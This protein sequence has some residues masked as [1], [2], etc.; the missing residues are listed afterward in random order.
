MRSEADWFELADPSAIPL[1]TAPSS[2]G[3]IRITRFAKG[4]PGIGWQLTLEECPAAVQ[5]EKIMAADA[6]GI[7][8]IENSNGYIVEQ[9]DKPPR[10][11][12][13]QAEWRPQAP[14]TQRC[15]DRTQMPRRVLRCVNNKQVEF[16]AA[17]LAQA[18]DHADRAKSALSPLPRLG[19]GPVKLGLFRYRQDK[20]IEIPNFKDPKRLYRISSRLV[21]VGLTLRS[22]VVHHFA[23]VM[24]RRDRNVCRWP[25]Y[26][27]L[28]PLI[29]KCISATIKAGGMVQI[30]FSG[31][32]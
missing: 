10:E 29:V 3:K 13:K 12:S 20:Q 32:G 27:L 14:V 6:A 18:S 26:A 8:K 16:S 22:F 24:S 21:F 9:M 4:E 15:E 1:I 11:N 5:Q 31:S 28:P 2:P 17:E 23:D 30:V 25:V 7:V 19:A